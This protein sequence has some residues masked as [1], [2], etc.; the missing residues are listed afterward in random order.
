MDMGNT[1]QG[2]DTCSHIMRLCYD[3]RGLCNNK[4]QKPRKKKID[5]FY[6]DLDLWE[7]S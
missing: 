7:V 2:L 1:I 5:L 6:M 4:L 3:D